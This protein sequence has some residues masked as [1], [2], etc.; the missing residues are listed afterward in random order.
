MLLTPALLVTLA[1]ATVAT[2]FISG[3]LGMAGGMI[4]MG[5]L[6]ALLPLPTAMMMHGIAQLAANGSRAFLLR[7][8]IAWR[9]F[10]GY[11]AGAS[12]ALALFVMARLVVDKATALI[13]MG[14]APF[15]ALALPAKVQLDVARR[16]HSLACGALCQVLSFTAGVS[17]PLLDAFFVRSA[18]SRHA[19]IATKAITQSLSHVMKIAYFGGVMAVAGAEV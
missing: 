8:E 19:V 9:V 6:L 16:G 18:M 1:V 13:A 14:L 7:K 4:L 5:V 3:I 2:S 12:L 10:A 15:A 17:G 11:A